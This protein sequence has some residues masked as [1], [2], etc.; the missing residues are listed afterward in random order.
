MTQNFYGDN[1]DKYLWWDRRN[2]FNAESHGFIKITNDG[3]C[4]TL[5]II[6][7]GRGWEY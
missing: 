7:M 6:L 2:K 3:A 5:D 4:G 1:W